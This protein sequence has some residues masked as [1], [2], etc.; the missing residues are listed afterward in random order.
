MSTTE[1]YLTN[2]EVFDYIEGYNVDSD[3]LY[4]YEQEEF[5]I[6]PY[7]TFYIFNNEDE[8][9]DLV[10][11]ILN[12]CNSFKT[13]IIDKDLKLFYKNKNSLWKNLNNNESKDGEIRVDLKKSFDHDLFYFIGATSASFDLQSAQWAYSAM[14]SQASCYS[15]LKI[16]FSEKW[17]N[18]NSQKW[19]DFVLECLKIL[20]PIQA[21]SGF[22]IGNTSQFPMISPE[23]ETVERIFSDYFYGLDIDH[24]S[25]MAFHSHYEEDD[26]LDLTTLGAGIRTPTWCFLLSPYWIEKLELTEEEIRL[27]LNDPRIEI[28]KLPDPTN[29]HKFSLWIRLG[30]LS[31]YP[32]EEGVPDLLV[33][34]NELI[35]PIRCNE[36]KLTT[37]DAWDDDPNPRF[38]IESSPQWIARFDQDSTWPEGNRV[39]L[40]NNHSEVGTKLAIR[41]GEKCPQTGYWFT[42][43]KENSRQYFKEDEI[44]PDIQ[45]DWGDV[46]WQFDGEK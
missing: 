42:V 41:A 43:A 46:Y 18:K 25:S 20:S 21:Y 32:V 27:K 4:G 7:I 31:L 30:D 33:M 44:L 8:S 35:Q 23:F 15:Y 17:H 40:K 39:N 9:F 6:C 5:G 38:D 26:F 14:L 29:A 1:L 36:L 12:I 28:T 13:Q 11:K 2:E 37:L 45:S 10:D 16:T 34:A 22:E 19:N 24:P 3:H